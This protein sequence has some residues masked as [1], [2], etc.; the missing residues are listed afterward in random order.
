MP[1]APRRAR[2]LV[3]LLTTRLRSQAQ[4]RRRRP[5]PARRRRRRPPADHRARPRAHRAARRCI[6]CSRRIPSLQVLEYWLAARPRPRPPR[7]TWDDRRPTSARRRAE[8][9]AMYAFDPGLRKIH[10]MAP[11]LAEECRHFLA[12]SF[13]DDSFEVNA[14]VPSYTR[15]V[16]GRRPRRGLSAAPPLCVGLV[17]GR[18]PA[19]LGA[20]VPVHLKHLRGAAGGLSRRLHRPDASRS[21]AGHGVV[22]RADRR[23]PRHL[24][25]RHRP[26]RDRARAARGVGG[27]RRAGDGGARRATI[28]RSSTTSSSADFV[29]DPIARRARGLRALR[30]RALAPRPSGACARGR[31]AI[32][33][34]RRP[35]RGAPTDDLGSP[36]AAVL[37]RFAAYMRHFDLAAGGAR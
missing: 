25:A 19:A 18:R 14:T 17:G 2:N 30:A 20:Q 37:E 7:A 24:R 33:T 5:R 6:I 26:R 1:A 22:R 10:L 28:R 15:L 4:M 36:R 13:T 27:R 31:A 23:L 16:R 34:A 8:I 11:D 21:G 29:A 9:E 32:P 35:G 12:Q 3:Q